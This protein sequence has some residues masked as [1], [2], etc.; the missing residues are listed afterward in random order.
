MP[1]VWTR[2]R[3]RGEKGEAETSALANSG[4]DYVVLTEDIV[5][6]I[7]PKFAGG[8]VEVEVASGEKHYSPLYE[9]EV[10]LPDAKRTC[11][12]EAIVLPG[13]KHVLLGVSALE[14][15]GAILNMKKG[16]IKFE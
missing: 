2:V 6:R 4:A 11:V 13:R 10:E 12:A 8:G 9:V 7:D 5:R 15:L 16:E 14:K 3:F 1:E